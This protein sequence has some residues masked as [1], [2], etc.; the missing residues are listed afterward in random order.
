MVLIL[1][2][3]ND[4]DDAGDADDDDAGVDDDATIKS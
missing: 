4:D 3:D 1:D 2:G